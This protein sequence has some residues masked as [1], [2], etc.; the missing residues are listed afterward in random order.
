MGWMPPR[1]RIGGR[2]VGSGFLACIL[3]ATSILGTGNKRLSRVSFR[4]E[5]PTAPDEETKT[6]TTGGAPTTSLA[7]GSGSPGTRIVRWKAGTRYRQSNELPTLAP[8][9]RLASLKLGRKGCTRWSSPV[10]SL[11]SG[12]SRSHGD[13]TRRAREH[14]VWGR[15]G[16]VV[17]CESS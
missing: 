14:R 9:A 5:G 2:T 3:T 13:S 11:G 17:G 16:L 1:G 10:P 7:P 8:W 15:R 6:T 12:R 4:G